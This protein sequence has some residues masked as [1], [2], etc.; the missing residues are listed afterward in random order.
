MGRTRLYWISALVALAV[1]GVALVPLLH[2]EKK[3]HPTMTQSGQ[4]LQMPLHAEGSRIVDARGETVTFTGVNWFGLETNTFAP[5][6]LWSRSLD[7]MLDQMVGQGFNSMRLP[8]SN[9]LF[10][11]AS[12][13]NG[14][15]YA[16][17]PG[18]KGMTG[19]QIMD[20]VVQGAT[21]RGMMVILDRHRPTSQ[22]QSNLWYTDKV[23]EDRW[24]SDWV[25][26][27]K[28]YKDN[29]LVVG[30]DLHNEPHGEATWGDGNE[31]TDW[32]A[33]AQRAGNAVLKA[34]P[35]WLILVEGIENYKTA[36]GKGDGYW[37]GGNLQGAK[38]H[39]VKLSDN[40]KLV[41]SAH[42]YSPKVWSQQWFT[43]PAFPA[44]MPALWDKQF[45]YLVKS[46]TA[47]VLVGEFGG[48]SVA[49]KD[50]QGNKDLEGIWQRNL[51]SY[52]KDNGLS[53]TY[54]AWNPNSGDTGGVL[55]D[56]WKTVDA[57]KAALLKTYQAPLAAAA[58]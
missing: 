6:G 54:W 5:H 12:K 42:D 30:A 20:Q 15:D 58:Q 19:P 10:D 37:W 24:I 2:H 31:K 27:A 28:K 32:Q 50:A 47:P 35:N 44:N 21:K 23:S 8:F 11:A 57:D 52:L 22:G 7:D 56:D 26:L 9:E 36:D 45:G 4:R 29:P 40:S 41:Y 13:P 43:D 17:N 49:E 33:A 16:L 14:V 48:R 25:M 38:E 53:Y 1:A 3:V 18:L 46:N 34:N 51:V 55:K 39:P